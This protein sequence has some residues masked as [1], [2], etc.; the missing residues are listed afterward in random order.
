MNKKDLKN[1]D[2]YFEQ[3]C[4]ASKDPQNKIGIV[5]EKFNIRASLSSSTP[6]P[7]NIIYIISFKMGRVF[8]G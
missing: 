6:A 3:F 1:N 4:E 2:N 8:V 5:T 7:F